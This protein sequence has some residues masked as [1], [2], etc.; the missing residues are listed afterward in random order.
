MSRKSSEI[1]HLQQ[2]ELY[3]FIRYIAKGLKPL[4]GY[5]KKLIESIEL[6]TVKILNGDKIHSEF[7]EFFCE[8]NLIELFYN[9]LMIAKTN[10]LKICTISHLTMLLYNFKDVTK[11]CYMLSNKYLTEII[12]INKPNFFNNN[13]VTDYFINFLKCVASKINEHPQDLFYNKD[14]YDYFPLLY[15]ITKFYNHDET[16][17]RVTVQNV[18]LNFYRDQKEKSS[19]AKKFIESYPF[20]Q[21]FGLNICYIRDIYLEVKKCFVAKL[22]SKKV[23]KMIEKL[24][25]H[26]YF[27]KDLQSY[28]DEQLEYLI[29]DMLME[30]CI[31]PHFISTLQDCYDCD[32]SLCVKTLKV[33]MFG[34]YQIVT[35][36]NNKKL[37][38]YT[39]KLIFSH[40]EIRQPNMTR[41][42]IEDPEFY[43]MVWSENPFYDIKNEETKCVLQYFYNQSELESTN[44]VFNIDIIKTPEFSFKW[45]LNEVRKKSNYTILGCLDRD[46]SVSVKTITTKEFKTNKYKAGFLKLLSAKHVEISVILANLL[47]FFLSIQSEEINEIFIERPDKKLESILDVV[48]VDYCEMVRSEACGFNKILEQSIINVLIKSSNLINL[49][50]QNW[51]KPLIE[52][53]KNQFRNEI[54]SIL[55]KQKD[56]NF[57]EHIAT[58]ML[59]LKND[60]FFIKEITVK[61]NEIQTFLFRKD[62]IQSPV[63]LL[64]N[65]MGKL[66]TVQSGLE[67]F[68]Y[69]KNLR[70]LFWPNLT[71]FQDFEKSFVARIASYLGNIDST[72]WNIGSIQEIKNLK[73]SLQKINLNENNSVILDHAHFMFAE[74]INQEKDMYKILSKEDIFTIKVDFSAFRVKVDKIPYKE[75]LDIKFKKK[76]VSEKVYT[77]IQNHIQD[78]KRQLETFIM[79]AFESYEEDLKLLN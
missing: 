69:Q 51:Y 77:S 8:T 55:L 24:I 65:S 59:R 57:I 27:I 44:S 43:S 39:A 45:Y 53:F 26:V 29:Q 63:Q 38:N 58:Y 1:D 67:K 34:L 21:F 46:L 74:N 15:S 32:Q 25:D 48:M 41:K 10:V 7:F 17:V 36:I 61:R 71:N 2:T 23:D 4:Y 72:Y 40:H 13:E 31:F 35:L 60:T 3:D 5:E 28:C 56:E 20:V 68:F 42:T 76:G 37:N 14:K 22:D 18:V 54:K 52:N 11:Q 62:K 78:G 50:E 73:Y 33:S 12:L 30:I 9:I 70:Y 75:I 66:Q 49:Y 16:Q 6:I 79:N 47:D 64:K 19:K